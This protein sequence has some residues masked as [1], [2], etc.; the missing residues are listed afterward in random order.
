MKRYF[1]ISFLLVLLCLTSGLVFAQDAT[2]EAT[3]EATPVIPNPTADALPNDG[4]PNDGVRHDRDQSAKIWSVS[5][6]FTF[7]ACRNSSASMQTAPG[8]MEH[9][10]GHL[11]CFG[12][13][14]LR[15]LQ[16]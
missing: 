12:R 7:W 11:G 10:G 13:L 16:L 4:Y 5:G 8:C 6:R 1:F 3:P 14:S 2:P 9:S 15:Y